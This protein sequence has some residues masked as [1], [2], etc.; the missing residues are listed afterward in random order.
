MERKE[1]GGGG[2][3]E[4]ETGREGRREGEGRAT[5][6]LP[7]KLQGLKQA[8]IRLS[9]NKVALRLLGPPCKERV[10]RS[11]SRS[12]ETELDMVAPKQGLV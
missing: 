7:W 12:H 4:E 5:V 9:W 3:E 1:K 2:E 11:P 8:P 6:S 10:G